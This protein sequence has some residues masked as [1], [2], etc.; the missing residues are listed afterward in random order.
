MNNRVAVIPARGGSTRLKKKNVLPLG[1]K[2]LIC[3][4]VEAVLGSGCFDT[5][6]VA[7]DADYIADVVTPY[8]DVLVYRRDPRHADERTTVLEALMVM[9]NDIP[10]YDVFA[11]FLPTCPFRTEQDIRVGVS[12]LYGDVDSVVSVVQYSDPI[13]LAME[14][15]Q[16][17]IMKPV[18]DNLQYGK[19][20]SKF[21][22]KHY[23]PNGSF[24]ISSWDFL[25]EKKNFFKGIT[26]GYEM[27]KEKSFDID[28]AYDLRLANL[29][30]LEKN[31]EVE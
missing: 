31:N 2:P 7:T 8:K 10:K 9:M 28:D 12:M 27:S 5:V 16:N 15:H 14:K 6:Y 23:R 17:S 4:T 25:L 26:R 11:Y 30:L 22:T 13:Q 19:T 29:F 1:G 24:Y 21:I 3:H 20:N 18:F